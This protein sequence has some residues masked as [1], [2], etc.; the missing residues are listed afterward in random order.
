MKLSSQADESDRQILTPRNKNRLN[1]PGE[2][3]DLPGQVPQDRIDKAGAVSSALCAV[4]C[5]ST[6][7]APTLLAAL[8]LGVFV[9][10]AFEWGFTVVAILLATAALVIGRLRH[11]IVWTSVALGVGIAGLVIGRLLEVLHVHGAGTLIGVVAGLTLVVGHVC[12][13][14][15]SRARSEP[16]R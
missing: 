13:I 6:A 12:S 15:A 10:P 11:Q 4:H 8:G 2:T 16:R 7:A 1:R 5:A 14:R 3:T 9:G